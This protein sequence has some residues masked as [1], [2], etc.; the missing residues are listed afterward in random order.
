MKRQLQP[1]PITTNLHRRHVMFHF[2]RTQEQAAAR[3]HCLA[4]WKGDLAKKLDNK[5]GQGTV[6]R[7]R[8]QLNAEQLG[9]IH[10]NHSLPLERLGSRSSCTL[11]L[12]LNCHFTEAVACGL[13]RCSSLLPPLAMW[14]SVV[15]YERESGDKE[16][17]FHSIQ[18][19][20]IPGCSVSSTGTAGR[21]S[22]RPAVEANGRRKMSD[23]IGRY[24]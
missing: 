9:A 11:T 12:V 2:Q 23:V 20:S 3:F 24:L 16:N 4:L 6:L 21:V 17:T 22:S 19:H 10:V 5:L 15:N 13:C 1:K 18:F 8:P 7:H 14:H